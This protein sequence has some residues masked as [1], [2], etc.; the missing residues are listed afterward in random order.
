M[1]QVDKACLGCGVSLQES[2]QNK[3]GYVFNLLQDYCKSCYQLKHYGIATSHFHPDKLPKLKEDSL[4]LVISSVMHLDLLFTHSIN[5]HYPKHKCV[6]IINQMDLLPKSTNLE[7]LL[8]SIIKKAKVNKIK[9]EDIIF[10][11]SKNN[12]DLNNLKSYL[13]LYKQKNIYLFGVQNSGKTTILKA[14]T[15]NK[16]ALSMKKA[17]LTLGE[18]S[19]IYNDKT[20]YD[21]P[22]LYQKGYLHQMLPYEKYKDL[23]IEKTIKPTI[24][25]LNQEQSI[26]LDGI[27][28]IDYLKGERQ[29]F[30]FYFAST[31]LFHKTNFKKSDEQ[32]LNVN[33]FNYHFESYDKMIFKL[34]EYVKYQITFADLGFVHLQGPATVRVSVA[35]GLS[36]TLTEALFK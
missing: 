17:A 32:L 21:M 19:G 5:R 9:Y 24:Y 8:E 6:Y 23:L 12:E 7:F 27:A 3:K 28:S 30:V 35:K 25:Q 20:I 29:A 33:L 11:S 14:L 36:V 18:I 2:D 22:G 13:D 1:L 15:N 31:F 16:T 34:D 10:M 26:I 4:I